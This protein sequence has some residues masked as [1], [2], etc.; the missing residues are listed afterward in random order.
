MKNVYTLTPAEY[1]DGA[2]FALM[3]I[4]MVQHLL[5]KEIK[6]VAFVDDGIDWHEIGEGYWTWMPNNDSLDVNDEVA[7]RYDLFIV[8]NADSVPKLA[9]SIIKDPKTKRYA[10]YLYNEE[11]QQLKRVKTFKENELDDAKNT[12]R[13][14]VAVNPNDGE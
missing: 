5:A 1:R 6:D 10:G 7:E 8:E 2:A 14:L 11:K 9:A 4:S 13:V 3:R 12:L